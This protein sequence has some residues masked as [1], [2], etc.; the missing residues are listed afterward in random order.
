[1]LLYQHQTFS[2]TGSVYKTNFSS[3]HKTAIH[4][5]I[6]FLEQHYKFTLLKCK[7]SQIS[8]DKEATT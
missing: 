4:P 3:I 7:M 6:E 2:E 8:F 5:L 1:M